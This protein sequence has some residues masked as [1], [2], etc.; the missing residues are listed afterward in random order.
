MEFLLIL[1][2]FIR[3]QAAAKNGVNNPAPKWID[4]IINMD[5]FSPFYRGRCQTADRFSTHFMGPCPPQ[6][7]L[8]NK[9][10]RRGF[11]EKKGKVKNRKTGEQS[12]EGE[13]EIAFYQQVRD[14]MGRF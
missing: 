13:K 14:L 3:Y 7:Q 9:Q 2:D 8:P 4:K 6:E 1:Q 5:N 11:G 12:K 10:I